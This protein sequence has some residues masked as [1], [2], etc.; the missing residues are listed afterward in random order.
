MFLL[1]VYAL[2][3]GDITRGKR[4][5]GIERGKKRRHGAMIYAY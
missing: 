1:Y 3:A 2:A 5:H 4:R